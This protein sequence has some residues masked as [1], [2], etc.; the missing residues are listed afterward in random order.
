MTTHTSCCTDTSANRRCCSRRCERWIALTRSRL[1]GRAHI[2]WVL[3]TRSLSMIAQTRPHCSKPL[4][5]Y[6]IFYI[7]LSP[8]SP[9]FLL[10]TPGNSRWCILKFQIERL[11]KLALDATM[12]VQEMQAPLYEVLVAN[13]LALQN[14]QVAAATTPTVRIDTASATSGAP[15][16]AAFANYKA[17][18]P[19]MLIHTTIHPIAS[20]PFL[21]RHSTR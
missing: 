3:R 17:H 14:E 12:L 6:V 13:R 10:L 2:R 1:N 16:P 20:I 5:R 8:F 4:P 19:L 18:G 9:I 7:F 21:L 11:R 15:F